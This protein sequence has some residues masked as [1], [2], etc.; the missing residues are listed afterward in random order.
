MLQLNPER[1]EGFWSPVQS[2]LVAPVDPGSTKCKNKHLSSENAS[3]FQ[4]LI[5]EVG[6][7]PLHSPQAG[8]IR[9]DALWLLQLHTYIIELHWIEACVRAFACIEKWVLFLVKKV[10]ICWNKKG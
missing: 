4:P 8:S 3:C 1:L 7:E 10:G 9:N 6:L 2:G 5:S